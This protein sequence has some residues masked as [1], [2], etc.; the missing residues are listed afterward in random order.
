[1]NTFRQTLEIARRDFVQRAKSRAFLATVGI[2]VAIVLGVGPLL[3]LSL[4]DP[5][6][7]VIG[8]ISGAP[9]GLGPAMVEIADQIDVDVELRAVSSLQAGEEALRAGTVDVVV[10][11]PETIIWLEDPIFRVENVVVA[12]FQAV[13]RRAAI[14]DLGLSDQ[15]AASLLA[16]G[17]PDSRSILDSDPEEEPRR[18]G[19]FIGTVLLYMSILIFGQ[20]VLMGVLEEKSSRVVEVVLSRVRPRQIL[21]GKVIGLGVLGLLQLI[22][23]GG[24]VWFT[25]SQIDLADVS[26]SDVSAGILVPVVLWY[27]LGYAFFSVVYAALGATISRQEDMQ[28]AAMIPVILLLPG[29]FI[30]LIGS[31]SPESTLVT[32]ASLVPPTSPIV[33]PMR[34]AVGDVPT[35]EVGVAVVVIL[36]TAWGLIRLG[37]RIYAGAILRIGARVKLREAWR[38]AAR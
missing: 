23:L 4:R 19:A 5:P 20:F 35:W 21:L 15:E 30:A 29:Y 10:A 31:E 34:Q 2:T 7:E 14:E 33:M 12:G 16:P 37:G 1:M 11:D 38:S 26:L 32:I 27:L 17:V 6:A 13:A 22:V 9:A 25:A 36:L 3:A 24:A 28:S 8:V 18:I